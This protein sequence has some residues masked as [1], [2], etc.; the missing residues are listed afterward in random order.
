MNT[1][2]RHVRYDRLIAAAAAAALVI[3][4]LT[5]II[6]VAVR[7]KKST[8]NK[9]ENPADTSYS[10]A[11]HTSSGKIQFEKAYTDSS[12]I[13]NGTLL[14]VNN[15]HEYVF[16]DEKTALLQTIDSS[17]DIKYKLRS[18][19]IQ[20]D[21]NALKA[22]NAMITDY[23]NDTGNDSLMITEGFISREQQDLMYNQALLNSL[24]IASGG[25]SE[26]HTGLAFDFDILNT[27]SSEYKKLYQAAC[28]WFE[29]NAAE[30]G[31]IIR[32]PDN[33]K[34][35]TGISGHM[36]HLRY[37]GIPHAVYMKENN[38][39]LEE[40]TEELKSYR[41]GERSLTVLHDSKEYNIYFIAA[42]MDLPD[43]EVCVPR[44]DTFSYTVSGNNE[45]GFIVTVE[46]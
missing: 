15:T 12:E 20:L 6:T 38:I 30:Y 22:M 1:N 46:K 41:Y 27:S 25:F 35:V 23:Y 31:F 40:Y 39:T 26:H 13:R 16:S 19:K 28:S 29:E 37:V 32:Y 14:L 36:N 42:S 45:D 44:S 2:K 11:E 8:Q 21:K 24:N 34:S 18:L 9:P 4:I 33:K 5:V 17:E 3:I 7:S 43:T 10:S